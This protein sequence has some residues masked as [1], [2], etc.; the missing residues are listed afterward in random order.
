MA[1]AQLASLALVLGLFAVT[2]DTRLFILLIALAEF[3]VV[4]LLTGLEVILQYA[5]DDAH[6]GRV[7]AAYM[8]VRLGL[9]PFGALALGALAEVTG[10]QVALVTYAIVLLVSAGIFAVWALNAPRVRVVDGVATEQ[11]RQHVDAADP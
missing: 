6:R 9:I 10:P 2:R 1:A 3:L 8:V 4:W 7:M 11:G 5:I